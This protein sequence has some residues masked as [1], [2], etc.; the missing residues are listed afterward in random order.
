MTTMIAPA[1]ENITAG[2]ITRW[3]AAFDR[4]L[5][6]NQIP[7]VAEFCRENGFSRQYLYAIRRE[8]LR[9]FSLHLLNILVNNYG[10]SAHWLITGRGNM[11][12]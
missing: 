6:Q 12:I 10:V 4:L 2:I 7:N 11:G 3:F 8:P 9:K 1:S 5:E